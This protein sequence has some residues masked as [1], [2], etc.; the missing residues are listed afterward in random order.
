[1]EAG[2]TGMME[3][4]IRNG[5]FCGTCHNGDEAFAPEEKPLF[6]KPKKN[7][8]RCH[9]YGQTVKLEN[10]FNDLRRGLPRARYGNRI[11][12]LKA[13]EQG[14]IKLQD[15]IEG[16]S[17]KR[18]ELENPI[19][20]DIKAAEDYMPDIIF[21]H[22][23]HAVWNGCE[24]CHPELFGVKKEVTVYSMQ[25]IFEGK[26]CGACHGSVAFPNTDCTLCHTKSV[27]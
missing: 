17:L 23:K 10:D 11:D 16:I 12:W 19:D 2:G 14:L 25:D 8:V 21:S 7:C 22:K 4:D 24:L 26:F 18:K 6:G 20:A 13:E 1:M 27:Y 3:E 9:S 15:H 5:L